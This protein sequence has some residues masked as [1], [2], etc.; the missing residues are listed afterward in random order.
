[1]NGDLFLADS[2]LATSLP[3]Q[4]PGRALHQLKLC[5]RNGSPVL[6]SSV[7]RTEWPQDLIYSECLE[8]ARQMTE[9]RIHHAEIKT[10]SP[11]FE[12]NRYSSL[13]KIQRVAAY[14]MRFIRV[15]LLQAPIPSSELTIEELETGLVILLRQSQ[16]D[17]FQT[18]LDSLKS[19]EESVKDLKKSSRLLCLSPRMDGDGLIRVGGRVERASSP[20][21]A[22]H[23]IVL[24]PKVTCRR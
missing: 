12:F 24:D 3:D 15:K 6:T 20:Y 23:P 17:S 13:T 11:L 22:K 10:I 18:E 8:E 5:H 4:I 21:D 14:V 16:S 2:T 1:M 19:A 7:N 9:A